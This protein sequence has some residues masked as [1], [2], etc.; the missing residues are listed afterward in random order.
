MLVG[1]G[2]LLFRAGF[3]NAEIRRGLD[4]FTYWVA[5]PSL[6][7][8]SLSGTD[9]AALQVGDLVAVMA[10]A[11]L[12]T[13]VLAILLAAVLRVKRRKFGVFVQAGFRGN[14]VFVGLPLIIFA[15]EARRSGA[16]EVVAGSLVAVAAMVP[17]Y[18]LISV[19][20]LVI[21]EHRFDLSVMPKLLAQLVKNPLIVSALVG[22]GLGWLGW[23]LPV[24]VDRPFTLLGQTAVALALVSIGGAL[25]ELEIRGHVAQALIAGVFKVTVMPLVTYALCVAF[26]LSP[27][28]TLVAM[29]FAACP[30]ATASFILTT[31]LGGD[32]AFAAA[33]VVVSTGLSLISLAFVLTWF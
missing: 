22:G 15:L 8:S 25:V 31:Q 20:A 19:L 2:A 1:L 10:L 23:G 5:L 14:M 32:D 17:L 28:W 24:V 21:A 3:I 26:A 13:T 9:F 12:A 29:I 6:F 33:C 4:W 27:E 18:N 16:D 7:I 30:T 11:G